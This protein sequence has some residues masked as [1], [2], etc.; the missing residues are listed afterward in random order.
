MS[1]SVKDSAL[2]YK[3]LLENVSCNVCGQDD[4][5]VIYPARYEQ[6]SADNFAEKFRSSGD[7]TLVDPM[8]RCKHCGF[9][10]LNPRPRQNM[11]LEGYSAGTDEKFVSQAAARENTFGKCLD[12]VEK[13]CPSRGRI[14]DIGAAAGAFLYV[15][16]K[17]GW[18]I[19]GCEPNRWM[20]KWAQTHYGIQIQP[21]TVFD[22]RENQ[23]ASFDAITLWD[24]LE[25]TPD[26][27]AVLVECARLLKP[28]GLLI[29]N[30]PDI[31]SWIARLMGRKWV[32]LLSVHLYYFTRTT[33]R[34]ILDQTGFSIKELR[35]HFQTLELGYIAERMKPYLPWAFPVISRM[36]QSLRLQ[37]K[38]VPYWIGQTLVIARKNG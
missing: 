22:L 1:K 37:K 6:A 38:L 9:E 20:C 10:Y 7:E 12:L 25:H 33:I 28:G 5:T 4:Y 36:V 13:Y 27:K 35:P 21:G 2:S 30:Y 14:L 15:A 29:V 19:A 8:V 23:A 3:D 18:Q 31:G 17:R 16:Q 11:I 32:F 24:V 26:A 34:T